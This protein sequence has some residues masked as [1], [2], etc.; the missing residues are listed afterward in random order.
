[1]TSLVRSTAIRTSTSEPDSTEDLSKLPPPVLPFLDDAER[2][3]ITFES[4]SEEE[5]LSFF[6]L[7]LDKMHS[8]V[9]IMEAI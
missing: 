7:A 1:M 3:P 6:G 9:E 2:T 8:P 5:G 4:M